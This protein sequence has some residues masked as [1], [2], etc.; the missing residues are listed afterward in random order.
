MCSLALSGGYIQNLTKNP[1]KVN[2]NFYLQNFKGVRNIGYNYNEAKEAQG[3]GLNGENLGFDRYL[4]I[5]AKIYQ[6]YSPLLSLFNIDPFIHMNLALAP[7]R[8]LQENNN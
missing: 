5:H 6:L 2:D 4:N 8:S 1:L 3:N 7:N